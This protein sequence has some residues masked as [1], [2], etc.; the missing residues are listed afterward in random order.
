MVEVVGDHPGI[1]MQHE[2]P[3]KQI[4]QPASPA[5]ALGREH[6]A[7]YE[8]CDRQGRDGEHVPVRI[9][10]QR[11]LP[12]DE[13][14]SHEDHGDHEMDIHIVEPYPAE[15]ELGD[16]YDPYGDEKECQVQY[17]KIVSE[18]TLTILETRAVFDNFILLI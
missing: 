3:R 8:E 16:E 1:G 15:D 5:D 9:D 7:Q 13:E 18:Q 17:L 11:C 14:E 6:I 12:P 10:P 2:Q 4:Y